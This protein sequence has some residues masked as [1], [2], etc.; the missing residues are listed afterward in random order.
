MRNKGTCVAPVVFRHLIM[1]LQQ[2]KPTNKTLWI[3]TYLEI[4]FTV[5]ICLHFNL[6]G[7]EEDV[8]PRNDHCQLGP[9]NWMPVALFT[10]NNGFTSGLR[11][12]SSTLE[13]NTVQLGLEKN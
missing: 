8:P 11:M 12:I 13:Q 9:L 2:S 6:G 4:R 1:I 7:D 5:K 10:G 3:Q